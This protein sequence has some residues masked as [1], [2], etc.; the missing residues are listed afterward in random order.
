MLQYKYFGGKKNFFR[1]EKF[2]VEMNFLPGKV[3]RGMGVIK[4]GP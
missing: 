2:I 4:I 3:I 1:E